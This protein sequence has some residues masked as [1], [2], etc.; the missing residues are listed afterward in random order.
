MRKL[1]IA[2]FALA[3][4]ALVATDAHAIGR[5]RQRWTQN[6]VTVP[7]ATAQA[8]PTGQGYRTY[9]YEPSAAVTTGNAIQGRS[10]RLPPH[11]NAGGHTAGYKLTD[12]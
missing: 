12:F 9:S 11:M 7:A 4:V 6:T 3:A 8:Q 10:T 2:G 5:R 1:I